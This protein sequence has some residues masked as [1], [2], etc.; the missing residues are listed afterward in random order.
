MIRQVFI[1][2]ILRSTTEDDIKI[3]FLSQ[4]YGKVGSVKIIESTDTV[5]NSAYLYIEYWINTA[6]SR[7]LQKQLRNK[8]G[9]PTIFYE[10]ENYT[11]GWKIRLHPM[12]TRNNEGRSLLRQMEET[13]QL[14]PK[15]SMEF[16][17]SDYAEI[18]EKE[19]MNLKNEIQTHNQ[20]RAQY[21]QRID[22]LIEE[23]YAF[24]NSSVDSQ[25]KLEDAAYQIKCLE[26]ERLELQAELSHVKEQLEQYE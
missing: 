15:E 19:N 6:H 12:L 5:F 24:L 2:S 1:P 25:R 9:N 16:V 18:L 22:D 8:I 21:T 17:S 10:T 23:A 11:F 20:E 26:Q 14:I 7:K 4:G 13:E 3:I